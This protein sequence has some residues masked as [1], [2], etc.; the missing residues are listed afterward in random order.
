MALETGKNRRESRFARQV[1]R[2]LLDNGE[3]TLYTQGFIGVKGYKSIFV[4]TSSY[5]VF[6]YGGKKLRI[7]EAPPPASLHT[8]VARNN[9]RKRPRAS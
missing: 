9:G 8:M 4:T 2:T 1:R 6:G 3:Q 7:R 5:V